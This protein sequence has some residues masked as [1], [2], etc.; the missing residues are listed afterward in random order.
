MNPD[1]LKLQSY[2]FEKLAQLKKGIIPP[3]D[4]PHIALSI[5][6]PQHAP[7]QSVIETL[8]TRLVTLGQYPSTRGLP[9]LRQAMADWLNRRFGL[10]AGTIDPDRHVL[11]CN[12]TREAIFS[13]AQALI[14]RTRNP[15]VL[16][17]NP[18][19][20]IYEG[21]ALLGGAESAY[22]NTTPENGYLPDFDDVP[23][24]VWQRCQLVYVCSPSNPTGAVVDLARYQKLLELAD[25]HD[26]IIAS[27][28]CYSEIYQDENNPPPG[29]LQA[30]FAMG[31]TE[32]ERC[33]VFH[34]LSKR[35]NLPGLRSGLIA[36]HSAL[37]ADFLRYRTYHGC[38]MP[39][40]TQ[41]ASI[42]AWQDEQHVRENRA[43]YRQKFAEV[44]ALLR[45][46]LPLT[47]PPAG[48]YL[49]LH[50]SG[51]DEEF[52]RRLFMEQNV[53]V[54]PGTYLSRTAQGINPGQ[55]HVRMA[56]VADL[57]GCLEAARRI[58]DFIP[59]LQQESRT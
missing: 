41:Y 54:L 51:N 26:F 31:N 57:D 49:W 44:H 20:P 55:H 25:R 56:L 47:I 11:P 28:E 13:F 33:V 4:K 39:L 12:G 52:A 24:S 59:T 19:Y 42:T 58:R 45:D 35:S 46:V 14:D 43:C 27:D 38:A 37:M 22:L 8:K 17:P 50:T 18:F 53:T 9:D 36:G 7:P 29:L 5:G 10:P 21:A 15:L 30:A 2:P 32:F 16:M 48:F 3:A 6:E 1:L 40:P 23:D 34:S